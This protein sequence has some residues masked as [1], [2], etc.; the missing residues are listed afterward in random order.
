MT[1]LP[2]L[3]NAQ[4]TSISYHHQYLSDIVGQGVSPGKTVQKFLSELKRRHVHQV[5][6]GY[7]VISWF[8][9]EVSDFVF[10]R[11]GLPDSGID[12]L[13]LI[14]A[15]GFPVAI[16]LSWVFDLTDSGIVVT[17]SLPD[18]EVRR[19]KPVQ[20]A[21][22]VLFFSLVAVIAFLISERQSA[23]FGG[24]TKQE[25]YAIG[26]IPFEN[27]SANPND[28]YFSDGISEELLNALVNVRQFRVASKHASFHF[29]D[30]PD[31]AS[32]IGA[33]LAVELLVTGSVRLDGDRVRITAQLIDTIEGFTIWSSTYNG[34]I[35]DVFGLQN[36]IAHQIVSALTPVI[37]PTD[38]PYVSYTTKSAQAFNYYLKG[39]D[40]LR[41]S[42]TDANLR[43]AVEAFE[44]ALSEDVRFVQAYAG[45]CEALLFTYDRASSPERFR[46]A[47][48]ACH[49]ALTRQSNKTRN[50]EVYLA[51]AELH[52]MAGEPDQ[53]KDQIDLALEQRADLPQIYISQGK[54]LADLGHHGQAIAAFERAVELNPGYW[55][56][57]LEFGNYYY[58]RA[59]PDY[60]QA[61]FHYQKILDIEPDYTRALISLG[62]ARYMNNQPELAKQAW[63]KSES[64]AVTESRGN[65]AVVFT[66]RGLSSYYEE[67][68]SAAVDWQLRAIELN[69]TEH[70]YWGRL[71]ESYRGLGDAK[72]EQ[73]T[74]LEAIKHG[75]EAERINPNN[76]E[77]L[78]LLGLY[79]AYTNQPN[80]STRYQQAML[81]VAPD[82]STALYFAS[83]AS[84]QIGE[85]EVAML[86]LEAAVAAGASQEMISNDPDLVRLRGQ[87]PDRM[88]A[89]F[90]G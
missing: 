88:A 5:A 75:L 14:V 64:T 44:N 73:D 90:N 57:H 33:K 67:D 51:L 35:Q 60:E 9:L 38:E 84:L 65:L 40:Y 18:S 78:G 86:H 85:F 20:L 29:K 62:S 7:A 58:N 79:Y 39:R 46:E 27:I 66:N 74:Y 69:P 49:R 13:L 36:E 54:A 4:S 89:L 82:N 34:I 37:D 8:I 63:D 10:P 41:S 1:C 70:K 15:I 55:D 17:K 31:T 56:A 87:Y 83:L 50:W 22:V 30:T 12:I 53:A 23:T 11:L 80:E 68:F 76:W 26:V 52:R 72:K 3:V 45:L 25:F 6:I 77:T 81:D 48:G 28:D 32:Q 61:I 42:K 43:L 71:A 19:L 2:I 16:I 24:E 47:E 59:N 21:Q